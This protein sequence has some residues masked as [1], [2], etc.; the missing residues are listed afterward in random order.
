[1]RKA[2]FIFVAMLSV[3]TAGAQGLEYA[4]DEATHTAKV[5]YRVRT[6]GDG[7]KE[8]IKGSYHGDIV[9]P[10]T[11]SGYT[12][13]GVGE[14]AFD[15]CDDVPSVKFPNTMKAIEERAFCGC[16]VLKEV[17][18]PASVDTIYNNAFDGCEA[19]EKVVFEDGENLL[20]LGVGSSS[21]ESGMFSFQPV[22]SVYIGRPYR[23]PKQKAW[24]WYDYYD[25]SAFGR[26][27]T[28]EEVTFGP[29][30]KEIQPYEFIL[31]PAL[32]T[33]K[34][35]G[36]VTTV[37]TKAFYKC[38]SLKTINLPEGLSTI[39]VRAFE[40]CKSLENI[41]F[42]STL[43]MIDEFAFGSCEGLQKLVIP[44]S[45]GSLGLASFTACTSIK[46]VILEDSPYELI[47]PYG[48]E[49]GTNGFFTSMPLEKAYI[50]RPYSHPETGWAGYRTGAFTRCA[51]LKEVRFGD[52]VTKIL[53]GDFMELHKLQTVVL[54]KSLESIGEFG[55][56]AC[57]NLNA[58][59]CPATTPPVCSNY[60]FS[61]T[62]KQTCKLYV[63]S[64]SIEL[65]KAANVWKEFFNIEAYVG[66]DPGGEVTGD[67]TEFIVHLKAGGTVGYALALKPKVTLSGDVFTVTTTDNTAT[68]QHSE[69]EKFTLNVIS[70][71][72]SQP[73]AEAAGEP[74]IIRQVGQ[75]TFTGCKPNAAIRIYSTDGKLLLTSQTDANG[76]AEVQTS[77]LPKG[78][79]V[80]K[81]DNV[82]IKIAK[83]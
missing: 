81:S 45:V 83:R 52:Y 15:Q 66:P 50:G 47:L 5:T 59:T 36:T 3:I 49:G 9:I 18:I 68:Y 25:L 67:G 43:T 22:K 60:V 46:E 80:V 24:G 63:P 77:Q 37:A 16:K 79:Y 57:E 56:T 28:L 32:K 20:K 41:E 26:C 38:E 17:I 78:I 48:S 76:Y 1:M 40:F 4:Y 30:V 10:E 19:L 73:I 35:N 29:H 71:A 42:P 75:L 33:V 7:T 23:Y 2:L 12:V 14:L 70:T 53:N 34:I 55:F 39:G 44:A 27:K 13:T 72:I 74:Q 8:R 54:P 6:L 69:V 31:T 65:Y 11:V 21:A 51:N 64:E 82:T 62:D 61:N 58:I